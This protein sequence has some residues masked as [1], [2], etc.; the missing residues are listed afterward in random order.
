MVEVLDTASTLVLPSSDDSIAFAIKTIEHTCGDGLNNEDPA[1]F[2]L[3]E[4]L[5][6]KD[7]MLMDGAFFIQDTLYG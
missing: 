7:G 6:E 3:Q 4:K 5:D 1:H 2:I